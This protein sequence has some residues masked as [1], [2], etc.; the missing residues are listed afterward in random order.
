MPLYDFRCPQGHV[1]EVFAKVSDRE[2]PQTCDCGAQSE[3]VLLKP[4][5]LDYGAMAQGESAGTTA[6]DRFERQHKQQRA[7]EEKCFAR[8]GD[9]G[10]APGAD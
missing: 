7:K 5:S 10:P 9:Y 1:T 8:N 6:I 2:N 4:P 3:R